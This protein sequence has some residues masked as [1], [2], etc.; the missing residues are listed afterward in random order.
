MSM[1]GIRHA[2]EQIKAKIIHGLQTKPLT[3]DEIRQLRTLQGTSSMGL[4]IALQELLYSEKKI[5]VQ[6]DKYKLC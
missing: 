4:Y 2:V 1:P 6:N 5:Q 3:Y